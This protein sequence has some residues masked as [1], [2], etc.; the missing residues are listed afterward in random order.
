[1]PVEETRNFSAGILF[2]NLASKCYSFIAL[3]VE[4]VVV[5]VLVNDILQMTWCFPAVHVIDPSINELT[6]LIDNT[7]GSDRIRTIGTD[8]G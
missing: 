8:E 2:I 1:M 7:Q 3:L 6:H 5:V 4:L